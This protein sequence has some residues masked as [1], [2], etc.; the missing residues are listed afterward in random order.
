MW[1][2]I[3]NLAVEGIGKYVALGSG[4]FMVMVCGGGILPAIQGAVA[5]ASTYMTSYWIIFVGLAYLLYYATIGCKNVN[6]DIK[7]D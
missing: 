7:V 2:S 1:G 4:F 5:D 3:F 6:K